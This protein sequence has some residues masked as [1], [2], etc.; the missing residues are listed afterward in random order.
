M[1]SHIILYINGFRFNKFLVNIN[2]QSGI[3]P[4]TGSQGTL[5]R[6]YF[7][8][9]FRETVIYQALAFTL[10]SLNIQHVLN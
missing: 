10:I 8:V 6:N 7:N 1:L 9:M 4:F 3:N 5:C 2:E